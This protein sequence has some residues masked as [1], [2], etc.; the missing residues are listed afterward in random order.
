MLRG[1]RLRAR[2]VLTGLPRGTFVVRIVGVTASGR[3]VSETRTYRT[4]R[5]RRGRRHRSAVRR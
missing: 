5:P 3:H 4:C 2:V 1:R